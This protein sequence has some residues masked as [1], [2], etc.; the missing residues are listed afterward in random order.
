MPDP[1]T[2]TIVDHDAWLEARLAHLA[3]EKTFTRQRDELSRQRRQLPWTEVDATYRFETDEG[4][5]TLAELFDGR[6]QLL[7]YHFMFGPGW[8]EGCPSCSFWADTYDG[9]QMHLAA[10]DT[11]LVAVSL[12]PLDELNAYKARMGWTFPWYSSEGSTFNFDMGVSFTTDDIAAGKKYNF[13]TQAAFG[14]ETPGISV[15]NRTDDGRVFL[16]YQTFSRGLDMLNSTYHHLDLTPKGRDEDGLG[17]SMEWL[18][19]HD[20]YD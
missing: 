16:S 7:M 6:G 4:T 1:T 12:A 11:T 20:A 13:G 5:T 8:E 19:R 2:P 18:R 14:E 3:D 15:F 17:Y 9:T 10:R